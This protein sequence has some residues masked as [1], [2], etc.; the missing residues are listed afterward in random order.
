MIFDLKEIFDFP[1]QITKTVSNNKLDYE[2]KSRVFLS[3]KLNWE[4]SRNILEEMEL[5]IQ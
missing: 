2:L 5:D 3:D 4:F 1:W